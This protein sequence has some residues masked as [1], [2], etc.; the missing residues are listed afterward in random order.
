MQLFE[1]ELIK[2]MTKGTREELSVPFCRQMRATRVRR[3][4][5]IVISL[6]SQRFFVPYLNKFSLLDDLLRK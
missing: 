2:W 5:L 6:I 3:V 1:T 4:A